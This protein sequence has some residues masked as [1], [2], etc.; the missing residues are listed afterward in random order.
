MRVGVFSDIH[1]NIYAFEAVWSALKKEA[2]DSYFFLGD[3]CGYYYA[4]NEVIDLLKEMESLVCL[5]GN[6]DQMFL[7]SFEDEKLRAD[8]ISK[9]GN[10]LELLREKIKPE[11]L[12]F[13]R[14]LPQ[15]VILDDYGIALFHGSPWDCLNEYVYPTDNLE[16][17]GA[18]N[19]KM[20]FLGHTHYPLFRVINN[21]VVVNPGSC[22]QPRDCNRPSYAVVDMKTA[23]VEF[24]RVS[25]DTGKLIKD[26]YRNDKKSS[27]LYE[28]LNRN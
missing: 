4:Q 25:Y 3:I 7:K 6:H 23:A 20:V 11:N 1:G 10:S 17:F 19:Y 15:K 12:E 9:Y 21:V 24:K 27:Y 14:N 8:Y 26:I 2:C 5:M 28:V 16:R 18:L 22:G 13:I